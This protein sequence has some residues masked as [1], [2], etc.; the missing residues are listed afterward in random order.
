MVKQFFAVLACLLFVGLFLIVFG[1]FALIDFAIKLMWIV[2]GFL[3]TFICNNLDVTFIMDRINKVL[4]KYKLKVSENPRVKADGITFYNMQWQDEQGNFMHLPQVVVRIDAYRLLLDCFKADRVKRIIEDVKDVTIT[5]P[6]VEFR[7]NP[8]ERGAVVKLEGGASTEVAG[9]VEEHLADQEW[10]RLKLHLNVDDGT[11][12]IRTGDQHLE[13][14]NIDGLLVNQPDQKEEEGQH[15]FDLHF[16]CLYEGENLSIR[17]NGSKEKFVLNGSKVML[18]KMWQAAKLWLPIIPAELE[19]FEG[20]MTDIRIEVSYKDW[21][22]LK[23]EQFDMHLEECAMSCA[24]IRVENL[25]GC[26]HTRDVNS[27]LCRRLEFDLNEQ[28]LRLKGSLAVGEGK[29]QYLYNIKSAANRFFWNNNLDLYVLPGFGINGLAEF[30]RQEIKLQVNMDEGSEMRLHTPHDRTAIISKLQGNFSFC[31]GCLC[32]PMISCNLDDRNTH[33]ENGCLNFNTGEYSFNV[34]AEELELALISDAPV[35]GKVSGQ[36]KVKGNLRKKENSI[37]GIYEISGLTYEK[38]KALNLG[39]GTIRGRLYWEGDELQLLD[40]K[41]H[42]KGIEAKVPSCH[43]EKGKL[44]IELPELRSYFSNKAGALKGRLE[45]AVEGLKESL[46]LASCPE[47]E[48]EELPSNTSE[49]VEDAEIIE[50]DTSLP[51]KSE[52]ASSFLERA[53]KGLEKIKKKFF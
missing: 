6:Y 19:L 22:E 27:I 44:K 46:G 47:S 1:G 5:K 11:L 26:F 42:I 39:E 37:E 29:G 13:F 17:N 3:V 45:E 12:V 2:F 49:P 38:Y 24:G 34:H 40:N 4:S 23:L 43:F 28:H 15:K 9:L 18:V 14:D 36:A 48:T 21:Q 7:V 32:F 41:L 16:S 51:E 25:E 35:T 53:Q 8:A 30:S 50:E 20:K 33:I 10:E 31:Q 52:A